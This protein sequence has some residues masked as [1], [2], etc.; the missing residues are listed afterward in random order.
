MHSGER[1]EWWQNKI[2]FGAVIFET[3]VALILIILT[4]FLFS[5]YFERKKKPNLYL[6]LTFLSFTLAT[7][8]TALGRWIGFFSPISYDIL[9]IT[10]LTL[11]ISYIFIAISN[12]FAAA[13]FNSI[14][15]QKGLEFAFIFFLLNGVVIGLLLPEIYYWIFIDQSFGLIREVT[16]TVI[17]ASLAVLSL[18]SYGLISILA[19]KEAR[20]NIEKLPKIGFNLIG[21]YGICIPLLFV[22]F[23]GDTL[24]ISNVEL[25]SQGYTPFYYLGWCFALFGVIL[26]YLGYIM[27]SWL[28]NFISSDEEN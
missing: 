2:P 4:F 6:G 26:G 16:V 25:F 9:S 20:L 15:I 13:F 12:C 18:I 19:F 24:L 10:D 23:T 1:M 11:L 28:K 22:F 8:T 17:M 7:L 5:K 27:P 14:F 21:V 3:I